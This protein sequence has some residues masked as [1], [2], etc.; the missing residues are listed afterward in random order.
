M[1]LSFQI[2]P[3]VVLFSML[4]CGGGELFAQ[5]AGQ[6]YRINSSM[7]RYLQDD[8]RGL[9]AG[10]NQVDDEVK[11][12]VLQRIN[13][14]RKP[15]SSLTV[16]I[17]EMSP[18][19]P[20]DWSNRFTNAYPDTWTSYAP[21]PIGYAWTAPNIRYQPLYYE[22]VRLERYGQ[23]R[24][25]WRE[26]GDSSVHFASSFFLWP[27]HARFDHV[28]SCDH[29]LGFCRPGNYVQSTKQLQWWGW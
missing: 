18:N 9:Q 27:Y 13:P 3:I 6:R 26:I 29:P 5:E 23:T 2:T 8:D 11:R 19:A 22:N 28:R 7:V 12:E 16:D 25:P 4:W 17:R 10:T 20:D 24:G 1:K 14:L 15:M 21:S